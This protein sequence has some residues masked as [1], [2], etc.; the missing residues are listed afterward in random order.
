LHHVTIDG[1]APGTTYVYELVIGGAEGVG[2]NPR[3][4]VTTI[5]TDG[6]KFTFLVWGDPEG[7]GQ[8]SIAPYVAKCMAN[9]PTDP[10]F[11]IT[12][13]D[14]V[15]TA[16]PTAYDEYFQAIAE[17]ARSTPHLAIP[18]NHETSV[19]AE[20]ADFHLYYEYLQ[21]PLGIGVDDE[22]CWAVECGNTL[23]IGLQTLASKMTDG[24]YALAEERVQF[25]DGTLRSSDAEFKLVFGHFP[26]YSAYGGDCTNPLIRDGANAI[27]ESSL[28]PMYEEYDVDIVFSGHIHCYERILRDGVTYITAAGGG[29]T[30]FTA[31]CFRPEGEVYRRENTY[32][33]E[34]VTVDG[35]VLTAE[36]VAVAERMGDQVIYYPEPIVIDFVVIRR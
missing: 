22:E 24:T 12:L 32:F 8:G 19:K 3:G 26:V 10:L 36:T 11:F 21:L 33:Y 5:P 29:S 16:V 35:S 31:R 23:L 27:Y 34:R 4:E 28:T 13:G 14:F 18:G 6:R 7:I 30:I 25:L 20:G 17:L 2:V 15:N 1:L 9:D